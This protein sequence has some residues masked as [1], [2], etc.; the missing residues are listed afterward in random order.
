MSAGQAS[1]KSSCPQPG[2]AA[3]LDGLSTSAGCSGGLVS[4]GTAVQE[5]KPNKTQQ[6]EASKLGRFNII[7]NLG[8]VADHAGGG[9]RLVFAGVYRVVDHVRGNK[10]KS[11]QERTA[12]IKTGR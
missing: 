10:A 9:R 7:W 11:P 6:A 1:R 3:K 5:N 8:Y 4:G 12:A 2:R